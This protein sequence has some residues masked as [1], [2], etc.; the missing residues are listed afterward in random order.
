MHNNQ[1]KKLFLVTLIACI[2]SAQ[3]NCFAMEL[4]QLTADQLKAR[5]LEAQ[6]QKDDELEKLTQ[7]NDTLR[8]ELEQK[9]TDH[10]DASKNSDVLQS[11]LAEA[12]QK[13]KE[14]QDKWAKN[15][16]QMKKEQEIKIEALR[17]QAKV[18][19]HP[20][21]YLAQGTLP[22]SIANA[23]AEVYN[24]QADQV[25]YQNSWRKVPVDLLSETGR[26]VVAPLLVQGL[27]P[28]VTEWRQNYLIK[29][30]VET[31]NEDTL[32]QNKE[33]VELEV[34]LAQQTKE[35][36]AATQKH[37][38]DLAEA[39]KLTALITQFRNLCD[40]HNNPMCQEMGEMIA[41]MQR[42]QIEKAYQKQFGKPY[43][44]KTPKKS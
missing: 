18:E 39:Q 26:H 25:R 9:K 11:K 43:I 33:R 31:L 21:F 8:K 2:F 4:D 36:N 41:A 27:S 38:D 22:D 19:V 40:G 37:N 42:E 3:H 10:T 32:A 15:T 28:A 44:P 17:E 24:A 12:A 5:L 23:Q 6:K 13:F 16:D 34:K 20:T 29:T 1:N 30:R 35:N 7:Q 14:E